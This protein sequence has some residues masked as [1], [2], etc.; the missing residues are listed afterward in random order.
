MALPKK[1]T[2]NYFDEEKVSKLIV[3]YQRTAIKEINSE[4]VETVV[5]KDIIIAEHLQYIERKL[6][7]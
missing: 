7:L 3:E 4:G 2:K 1:K 5:W 6:E